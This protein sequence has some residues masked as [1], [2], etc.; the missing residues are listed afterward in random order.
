MKNL[1]ITL[2]DSLRDCVERRVASGEFGTPSDFV[3]DLIERDLRQP[4]RSRLEQLA[5]EGLESGELIEMDDDWWKRKY[6]DFNRQFGSSD[7]ET[8]AA[9][10]ARRSRLGGT[11]RLP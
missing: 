10:R 4:D 5:L 3:R 2:P 9:D 1:T 11:S 6:A 7:Y 8:P